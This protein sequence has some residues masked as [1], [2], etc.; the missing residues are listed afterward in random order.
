ML[1]ADP[2]FVL[3]PP[4]NGARHGEL[5]PF[6]LT[7]GNVGDLPIG[8]LTLQLALHEGLE[9]AEETVSVDDVRV[10][11]SD[12]RYQ[13]GAVLISPGI[14]EAGATATLRGLL[15]VRVPDPRDVDALAVV[16]TLSG[17]GIPTFRIDGEIP[18]DH[19]PAFAR[20]TTFLAP[21][22]YDGDVFTVAAT[23]TNPEALAIERLRI[24][25]D[26][27][28]A[29]VVGPAIKDGDH[30]TPLRPTALDDR[31][32]LFTDLGTLDALART[33]VML[34]LRPHRTDADHRTMRV[35]A[36]LLAGSER[37]LLGEVERRVAAEANLTASQIEILDHAPL[38]LGL[39]IEAQL[40]LRNDGDGP[41]RDVRIALDLPD[42]LATNLPDVGNG[43]RWRT[44][45]G[46]LPAGSSL[47]TAIVFELTAPPGTD[48]ITV[49]VSIDAEGCAAVALTPIHFATP[50]DP[51]VDPPEI[52][53]N[54]L[55]GGQLLFLSRI[56]NRGDGI[57]RGLSVRVADGELIVLRS[58]EIDGYIV[59]DIGPRSALVDGLAIGDLPPGAFRDVTWI[60]APLDEGAYRM[61]VFVRDQ[62]GSEVDAQSIPCRPRF[63]QNL[64]KA[65][66]DPRRL[67]NRTTLERSVRR[68]TVSRV[69]EP[70]LPANE[71]VALG[72]GGDEAPSNALPPPR[73]NVPAPLA[74]EQETSHVQ[75]ALPRPP[76]PSASDARTDDVHHDDTA[77]RTQAPE[78][79]Q[80]DPA[81]A[82]YEAALEDALD[83]QP[84]VPATPAYE[85]QQAA[86]I[87]P[88]PVASTSQSHE[89]EEPVAAAADQHGAEHERHPDEP[90]PAG[91][92]PEAI[93]PTAGD[94][95]LRADG[96]E[97]ETQSAILVADPHDPRLSM[98]F[99]VVRA[100]TGVVG[101]GWWRHILA[102]RALM[103]PTVPGNPEAREAYAR[104]YNAFDEPLR[105]IYPTLFSEPLHANTEWVAKLS[106]NDEV[107]RAALTPFL[108]TT[109]L[110]LTEGKGAMY[111]DT[112]MP[113]LLP[114]DFGQASEPMQ[115]Y[116]RELRRVF[117]YSSIAQMDEAARL[118]RY[119]GAPHA[120]LDTILEEVIR[121]VDG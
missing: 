57:A 71:R 15:R 92:A 70:A 1:I 10:L 96:G 33:T 5:V 17:S 111:L 90:V 78:A 7:I 3:N 37:V 34:R 67:D 69:D 48:E 66:P 64:A 114:D 112:M 22:E 118:A 43:S 31:A 24:Q 88:P 14:V 82:R 109:H 74:E 76:E 39:P 40:T 102:A 115:N 107:A 27:A 4:P 97:D 68:P 72:G 42:Y 2:T 98:R 35:R 49:P 120:T 101:I 59:D 93:P 29:K 58:T 95:D 45:A 44:V 55:D 94:H 36:T 28:E 12:M 50:S 65:L 110:P 26:I 119:G 103:A 23:V 73:D 18:I 53:V 60:T 80:H 16:G 77:Q 61:R 32:A 52:Q 56:I 86:E 75:H 11:P 104:L 85:Q 84:E 108:A 116:K 25:W 62:N 63:E 21:L 99:E 47:S 41:A 83:V 51:L 38:R 106:A 9:I 46:N 20:G 13:D 113:Q 87:A 91:D 117:G 8:D 105:A 121:E 89:T 79:A 81:T 19:R 54:A 6:A 30:E 100:L